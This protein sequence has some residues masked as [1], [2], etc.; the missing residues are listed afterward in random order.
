MRRIQEFKGYQ[1]T[2][3]YD[4]QTGEFV[5]RSVPESR[6]ELSLDEALQ[7]WARVLPFP[8]P[9]QMPVDLVTP[10]KQHR[11]TKAG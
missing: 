1:S 8:E 2:I 6:M 11:H 5:T 7:A 9:V 4:P 10:F 3:D